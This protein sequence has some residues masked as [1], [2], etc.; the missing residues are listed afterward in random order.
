MGLIHVPGAGACRLAAQQLLLI[1]NCQFPHPEV[2]V[3]PG[4]AAVAQECRSFSAF[5]AKYAAGPKSA[6]PRRVVGGYVTLSRRPPSANYA[7]IEVSIMGRRRATLLIVAAAGLS[8]ALLTA[9]SA[10]AAHTPASHRIVHTTTSAASSQQPSMGAIGTVSCASPGNCSAGGTYV[11]Q[12]GFSYPSVA[13]E[14]RGV[15]GHPAKVEGLPTP[16]YSVTLA[17]TVSVSCAS[18]G[19]CSAGGLYGVGYNSAAFVVSE[20]QGRWG[21]AERITG[22]PDLDASGTAEIESVSCGSPGN[23]GAGGFYDTSTTQ[24][25]FVITERHGIWGAAEP[26]AG[27]AQLNTGGHAA[28]DSVSCASARNCVAGGYYSTETSSQDFVVTQKHGTWGTARHL[29]T[30]VNGGGSAIDAVSCA[31]PGTCTVAG[32]YYNDTSSGL[33]VVSE[34]QGTWAAAEPVPGPAWLNSALAG[35]NSLSC[36]SPGNC[37]ATGSYG[38]YWKEPQPFVVT[39]EH[40]SWGQAQTVP[41]APGEIASLASVSCAAPG[42]CSAVGGYNVD[43]WGPS[44]LLVAT[45][46]HGTWGHAQILT[47]P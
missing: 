47:N 20:K 9:T 39:E 5:L 7:V 41:G 4:W 19:N 36:A 13:D 42:D 17:G 10:A 44:Y 25:A 22:L 8:S 1:G 15:W 3:A 29:P 18:P 37:S 43:Y 31:R 27:L 12:S 34:K 30:P 11:D 21:P 38:L 26:V 6:A 33:F 14:Q 40:G 28:I 32:Y 35:I 16:R 2:P 45:E 24:Q 46:R 23:C